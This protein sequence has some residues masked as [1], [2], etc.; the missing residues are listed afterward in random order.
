MIG[1]E[2]M[3]D[4]DSLYFTFLRASRMHYIRTHS[5]LSEIGVYHGQPPLLC[6]LEKNDGLSQREIADILKIAPPTI[7]VMLKRMEK[8]GLISRK[9][10][11]KDQRVSRVYL[12]QDGRDK[13]KKSKE[14]MSILAEECFEGFSSEEKEELKRFLEKMGNNLKEKV[15]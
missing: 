12:T 10:D 3:I 1:S 9:Q 7:T 13:C 4:K 5:L 2:N 14:A 11:F 15:E 8:A 6:A